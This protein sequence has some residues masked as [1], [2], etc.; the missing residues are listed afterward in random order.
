MMNERPHILLV[1]DDEVTRKTLTLVL[2]K[3]GNETETAAMGQE[4]LEKARER[5]FNLACLDLRLPDLEGVNLIA[6]LK[7]KQP[8]MAVIMV[9]GYAS[10]GTA[11]HLCRLEQTD[12]VVVTQCLHRHLAEF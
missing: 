7:E 10:V 3:K 11:V 1:D 5:A 8:H 6:P 2:R 4:A 12:H 9:T